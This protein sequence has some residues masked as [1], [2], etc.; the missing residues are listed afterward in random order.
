MH[1]VLNADV[2]LIFMLMSNADHD[3]K[4]RFRIGTT[5]TGFE[6]ATAEWG[7][8]TDAK[9]QKDW[10]QLSTKQTF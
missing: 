10:S 3:S 5:W 2:R 9:I 1:A 7:Q 6:R 4:K 8:Y